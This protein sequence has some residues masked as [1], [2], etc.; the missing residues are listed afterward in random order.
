MHETT[1]GRYQ[2]DKSRVDEYGATGDG[3]ELDT[4]GH[5]ARSATAPKSSI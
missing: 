2:V 4:G 5:E 1:T 3:E